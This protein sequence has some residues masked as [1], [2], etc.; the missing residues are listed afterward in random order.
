MATSEAR[1]TLEAGALVRSTL[2]SKIKDIAFTD[3]IDAVVEEDKGFFESKFRIKLSGETDTL[4]QTIEKVKAYLSS[5]HNI[6]NE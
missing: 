4:V 5:M 1:F 3:G 6:L 2:I